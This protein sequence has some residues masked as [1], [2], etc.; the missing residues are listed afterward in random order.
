MSKEVTL[1]IKEQKH[2]RLVNRVESGTMTVVRAAESIG[3]SERHVYRLIA[4]YRLEGAAALAH[5]KPGR[6]STRRIADQ[7]RAQ[8]VGLLKAEYSDN[9]D[10]LTDIPALGHHL[11]LS[12]S[13]SPDHR[14]PRA[15]PGPPCRS[16][17]PGPQAGLPGAGIGRRATRSQLGRL[18][19]EL[20]IELI[21]AYSPQAKGRIERVCVE[22]LIWVKR[23]GEKR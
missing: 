12:R 1:T 11:V 5:R 3:L 9:D 13:S 10:Q 2:L 15:S 7:V 6:P 4:R 8:V 17:S 14:A 16:E 20:G 19:D 23:I 22:M 18:L 21:P